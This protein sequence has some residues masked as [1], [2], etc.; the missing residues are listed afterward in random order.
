MLASE[1]LDV[2]RTELAAHHY[3]LVVWQTGTV[4][5]VR[6]VPTGEFYQTLS[7]GAALV[8][9]SGADL[10]LVD[11]QYSRFLHANVDLTSYMQSLEQVGALPGVILFHRFSLMQDWATDGQI[12]RRADTE[13]SAPEDGGG[14]ACLPW[15]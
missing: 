1:M 13:V 7:D 4:E 5:A 15:V 3:Q 2:L 6:N 12:D 9:A 11:P 10:M 8:A 14:A